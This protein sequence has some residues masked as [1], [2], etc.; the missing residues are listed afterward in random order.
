[1]EQ[2]GTER[3][4]VLVLRAWV[5]ETQTRGLRVR[6]MRV[7][8]STEPMTTATATVDGACAIVRVWL[9]ELLRAPGIPDP[10]AGPPTR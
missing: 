3:A 5:E 2:L 8:G 7:T 4:E 6:A 10:T 1:M 9:E